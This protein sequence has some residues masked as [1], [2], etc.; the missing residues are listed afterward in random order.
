MRLTHEQITKILRITHLQL[1]DD[2]AVRV[3]GSRLD[4]KRRGGDLDL[5]VESP[6]RVSLLQRADLKLALEHELQLPVDILAY[7]QGHSPT[8]FQAI[9]LAQSVR[10][11]DAA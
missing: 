5:L 6:R 9:A 8:A 2:V 1:G 4:D 7:Q 3:Y 11:E 10:L